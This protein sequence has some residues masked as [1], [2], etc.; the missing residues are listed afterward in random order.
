MGLNFTRNLNVGSQAAQKVNIAKAEIQLVWRSLEKEL[1]AFL[2]VDINVNFVKE[3]HSSSASLL[4][5][6]PFGGKDATGYHIVE[7]RSGDVH[8]EL[9]KI[10]QNEDGFP[11]TIIDG[12][13]VY[14]VENQIDMVASIG[15]VL[16]NPQTHI[17]L[18]ELKER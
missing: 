8:V 17:R 12:Q 16:E 11:F 3:F 13:H 2:G 9:F 14:G 6:S 5:L 10:K 18:D 4:Y 7:V 15:A 1:S